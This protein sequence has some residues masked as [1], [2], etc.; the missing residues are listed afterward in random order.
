M[1]GRLVVLFTVGQVGPMC[2]II[3]FFFYPIKLFQ[4]PVIEIKE[5]GKVFLLK[6]NRWRQLDSLCIRTQ[7]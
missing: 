3:G 7:K 5:D 4:I 2:D 1:G 6:F